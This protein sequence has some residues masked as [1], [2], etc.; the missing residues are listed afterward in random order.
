MNYFSVIDQNNQINCLLHFHP[1]F[2]FEISH[3][4]VMI[5]YQNSS[6]Q[7]MNFKRRGLVW[8]SVAILFSLQCKNRPVL[9]IQTQK[10]HEI[11]TGLSRKSYF[12]FVLQVLSQ[13]RQLDVKNCSLISMI[14]SNFPRNVNYCY[15]YY[16][17]RQ[18]CRLAIMTSK[19]SI[20]NNS[21]S[22][23]HCW[24][25]NKCIYHMTVTLFSEIT[26]V[27]KII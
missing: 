18:Q 11:W 17:L 2:T 25:C 20:W 3:S 21:L 15:C 19:R 4:A 26:H 8:K 5:S 12:I 13:K 1:R 23:N 16:Q 7:C 14:L 10:C 6:S 9:E 24:K 27:I 22:E